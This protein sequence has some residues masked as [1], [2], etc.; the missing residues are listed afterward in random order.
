MKNEKKI[1]L[2]AREYQKFLLMLISQ[3]TRNNNFK[4]KDDEIK[5]TGRSCSPFKK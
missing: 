5:E 4:S 3:E 2:L 1:L